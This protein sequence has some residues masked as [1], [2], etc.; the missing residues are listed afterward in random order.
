VKHILN[1]AKHQEWQV[2][3]EIHHD[4]DCNQYKNARKLYG[5]KEEPFF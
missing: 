5:I 4:A 2:D 3:N 1:R